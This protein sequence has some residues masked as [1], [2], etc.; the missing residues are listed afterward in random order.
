MLIK[1]SIL[2]QLEA[3]MHRPEI[4][5]I[6]GAR[7]VGK[8]TIMNIL[9]EK[10]HT[11][12][13]KTLFFNL[14]YEKDYKYFSS[15]EVLLQKIN[16][17]SGNDQIFV[18]ID[19]LQ[20]KENAGVFLKGIYDGAK[21]IKFVVSGSGS[22][23]LKENIHESLV[24]RK[25]VFELLP[26]SFEE[27]VNFR[28]GYR[29]QQ[30]LKAYFDI[31]HEELLRF[32]HEYSTYGGYP[33][34]VT[35]NKKE[36]KY[37]L[38][39]EIFS[40]YIQKDLSYLLNLDRPESF[41]KLIEWLS[42]TAGTGINYSTCSADIGL[43]LPT[44]KKYLWYAENTFII[45]TLTPFY[46]NK[47]KEI[48]K[49]P[50]VYFF[51][52]GMKNFAFGNFGA[53]LSQFN[54]GQIFENFIFSVLYQHVKNTNYRL[55]YW[56]T[57]DMAE[58]DFVITKGPDIIPVEVK[59]THLDKDR[60]G[61]AFLSFIT[62]YQPKTAYIINVSARFSKTVDGTTIYVIPFYDL[63]YIGLSGH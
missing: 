4:T 16:L 57:T 32:L 3:H 41:V 26:V 49:S 55:H 14:D 20:R 24:G 62:K 29:Y 33:A 58:V 52:L 59:F 11:E 22:L 5:M 48:S 30:N 23:E 9:R 8:T 25:R 46:S 1:R 61:R 60:F 38:M 36:E 10:L 27:F 13:H 6:T 47:R 51:D 43:S 17:E 56:R 45:K 54:T 50:V 21:N 53:E 12:D 63:F 19:E 18:F 2:S 44:V 31:E 40:S 35:E 34:V 37:L 28:T 15:Q 7:Q 42:H 39:N